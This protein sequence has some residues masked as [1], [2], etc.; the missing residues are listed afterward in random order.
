MTS[1][2]LI[3]LPQVRRAEFSGY[4]LEIVE[5]LFSLA[6]GSGLA[7]QGSDG[8]FQL[9]SGVSLHESSLGEYSGKIGYGTSVPTYD[10]HISG[11]NLGVD[12]TGYFDALYI[13]DSYVATEYVLGVTGEYLRSLISTQS[14]YSSSTYYPQTNPSG[15]VQSSATGGLV[16]SFQ[17]GVFATTGYV[18][19]LYYLRTNPSGYITGV[20]T[21][22]FITTGQT[23]VF[24]STGWINSFYYP[25]T[26]PSGYID[27]TQTGSFQ[28][29]GNYVL[30]SQTGNFATVSYTDS[31]YY[32]LTNPSGYISTGNADAR[33]ALQS[34]T[35]VL[36]N[37]SETGVFYPLTNP[38]GY[39]STGNADARYALQSATGVLL[40]RSETG[41]FYP[42]LNPSGYISTGNADARYALQSATGVLL[43]RSETGVLVNYW[44]LSSSIVSP[45]SGN[46]ISGNTG[47][48]QTPVF[49][50]TGV[51]TTTG[52]YG[53]S[54]QVAWDS[55]YLYLCVSNSMWKR[56]VLSD[57]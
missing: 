17:T 50:P 29:S 21:G 42:V 11:K 9:K 56:T 26:N 22:N 57:F 46:A 39:I 25:R 8:R 31:T 32:P 16:S 30:S 2:S 10:F 34:A 44:S 4:V 27:A 52:S 55:N 41:V 35:G 45:V 19:N 37:R 53:L 43:N 13:A 33:Y 36:L 40:N 49:R 38:S 20:D 14:G 1:L 23:G 28:P 6:T 15:Y 51:P 24:A 47:Y 12:G 5:P 18:E 48:F 3:Q 54:G 7:T